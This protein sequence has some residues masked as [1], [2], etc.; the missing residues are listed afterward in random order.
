MSLKVRS[1]QRP[2]GKTTSREIDALSTWTNASARLP[3][4]C[5]QSSPMTPPWRTAAATAP[6]PTASTI[7]ATPRRTRRRERVHRLG[8][9]DDVPSLL[10]EDLPDERVALGRAD[11]ELAA[12]QFAEV[13]LAQVLDHGGLDAGPPAQRRGRL[14]RAPQGRDEDA[15]EALGREAR[16]DRLGLLAALGRERRVGVAADRAG[17]ARRGPPRPTRRGGSSRSRSRPRAGRTG[18]AGTAGSWPATLPAGARSGGRRRPG[19]PGR[20]RCPVG[21]RRRG[22]SCRSSSCRRRCR[23]R[24]RGRPRRPSGP[25]PCRRCG[26]PGRGA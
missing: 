1:S 14:G 21:A 2:L 19:R 5:R 18:A 23:R 8:A 20:C 25:R 11:A 16:P 12:L 7:V 4:A 15:R 26:T 10:G 6:G 24:A 3:V 17:T 22:P 13:H 9:R